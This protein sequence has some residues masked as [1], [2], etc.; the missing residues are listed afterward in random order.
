MPNETIDWE[1]HK[2]D[3]TT[4]E[5]CAHC[6]EEVTIPLDKVSACPTCGES[7]RPCGDCKDH[8]TCDW[9]EDGYCKAFPTHR[10]SA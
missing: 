8:D 5:W 4:I 9:R 2:A 10:N 7:I 6:E 3:N 1:K